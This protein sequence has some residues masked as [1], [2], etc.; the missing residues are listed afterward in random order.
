MSFDNAVLNE[1][2]DIGAG[3]LIA[4]K[5]GTVE[6]FELF[7]D[8]LLEGR[9][10]KYDTGSI[11]KLDAS[12]TPKV[13]GIAKRKINGEIGSGVYSTSGQAI[14]QVAEI[15]TYGYAT[16][17]VTDAADPAKYAPVY[18]INLASAESGKATEDS[19]A[20]G[21]LLIANV[22]FWEQKADGVWLVRIKLSL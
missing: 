12:T 11:D 10:V 6:A 3:E 15:I 21:A 2:P 9:F 17:T 16:V 7:E 5:P 22:D 18:T 1:V 20:T 13:A 19:A 8:G 4:S 14:D